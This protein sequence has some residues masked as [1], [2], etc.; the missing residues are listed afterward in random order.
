MKY[1]GKTPYSH[2]NLIQV[3]RYMY[4]GPVQKSH[5]KHQTGGVGYP[6]FEQLGP[7][8]L[9]FKRCPSYICELEII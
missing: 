3:R 4:L 7:E 9:I 6:V 1:V 2:M 5:K 8:L